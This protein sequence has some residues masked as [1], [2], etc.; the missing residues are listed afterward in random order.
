LLAVLQGAHSDGLDRNRPS[1]LQAQPSNRVGRSRCVSRVTGGDSH[2]H[3]ESNV[4][5]IRSKRSPLQRSSSAGRSTIRSSGHSG[6]SPLKRILSL[7]V[8]LAQRQSSPW[9][10]PSRRQDLVAQSVTPLRVRQKGKKTNT[11]SRYTPSTN[12]YRSKL[13]R[14]TRP[15]VTRSRVRPLRA[16]ESLSGTPG[17]IRTAVSRNLR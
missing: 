11:G 6:T 15:R 3:S 12:G 8:S 14:H 17:L 1:K 4:F 16:T 9:M 7:L 10:A 2:H 5:R 13:G